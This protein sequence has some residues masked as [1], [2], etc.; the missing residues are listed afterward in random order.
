MST[1]H[2]DFPRIE[3]MNLQVAVLGL[4]GKLNGVWFHVYR[5]GYILANI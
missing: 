4:V 5:E 2:G 3:T 1:Q